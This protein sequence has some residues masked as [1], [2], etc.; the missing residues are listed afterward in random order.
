MSE[1]KKSNKKSKKAKAIVA[2][3]VSTTLVGIGLGVT[4]AATIKDENGKTLVDKV[5]S[6][7]VEI[8]DDVKQGV[9]TAGDYAEAVAYVAKHQEAVMDTYELYKSG[10]ITKEEMVELVAEEIDVEYVYE[11]LEKYGN[12]E[13]KEKVSTML[14]KLENDGINL[15]DY[16]D[17]ELYNKIADSYLD[18]DDEMSQ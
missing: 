16:L 4:M 10:E 7:V 6:K 12:E 17:D 14:I 3:A 1:V 13:V 18:N 11:F 2:I 9:E 5:K 15:D 8:A